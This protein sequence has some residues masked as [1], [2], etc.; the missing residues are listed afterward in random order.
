M[1]LAERMERWPIEEWAAAV[2]HV[3]RRLK[4]RAVRRKGRVALGT[5]SALMVAF[6]AGNALWQQTSR[7]P[8]PLWGGVDESASFETGHEQKSALDDEAVREVVLH[9]S[10][11]EAPSDLVR[12]VQRGLAGLDLLGGPATGV[13]DGA[14]INA[15]EAFERRN[16]MPRTGEPSIPLLATIASDQALPEAIDVLEVQRRLN[17]RGFG[18]LEE[19]GKMGPK[20]LF[21][22]ER[23]AAKADLGMTDPLSRVV[24]D[25]L[26][27]KGV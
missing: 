5:A 22:L 23:F 20:T 19:D 24:L 16:G 18:P 26:A 25:A 1:R 14:T 7:H 10:A 8:A 27:E 12:Q 21:A 15:I 4:R 9:A 6:V 3:V 2:G 11:D 17:A 13:L